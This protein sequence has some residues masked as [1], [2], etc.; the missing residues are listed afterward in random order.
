MPRR[1]F[2]LAIWIVFVIYALVFTPPNQPNT[3]DLIRNLSTGNWADINPFIIS[4]FNGMGLWPMAYAALLFR[5]GQRQSFPA[6]PFVVA[7]FFIGA[8]AILPYLAFRTSP[9]PAKTL[10]NLHPIKFWESRWLGYA[11]SLGFLILLS[12]CL[13]QGSWESFSA[14]WAS[15]RFIHVMSLDF[16]MLSVLIPAL[17][18]DDR[19]LRTIST[20]LWLDFIPVVGV[21]IY[22]STRST[23]QPATNL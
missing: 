21:L 9:S 15:D 5:D 13:S 2:Y 18:V 10:E 20:P 8:F 4:L 19:D 14:D 16:C 22:L 11:L 1:I 17:T 7:S 6:W 23:I 3:L 12:Y